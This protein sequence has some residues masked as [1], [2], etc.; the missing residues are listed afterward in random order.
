MTIFNFVSCLMLWSCVF[1][2]LFDV[3]VL[4][5]WL[6]ILWMVKVL[7]YAWWCAG[8]LFVY[9]DV[10]L[11]VM[12][13]LVMV[14]LLLR[15]VYYVGIDIVVIVTLMMVICTSCGKIVIKVPVYIKLLLLMI[16]S[17]LYIFI[18]SPI[19]I[20]IHIF[21]SLPIDLLI[22][23]LRLNYLLMW[24][25]RLYLTIVMQVTL[26]TIN[27]IND[28]VIILVLFILLCCCYNLT[29]Y[30]RLVVCLFL[31]WL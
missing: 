9:V 21:N 24:R 22:I 8:C 12:M 13:G 19:I 3:I 16:L 11:I 29:L 10:L 4:M 5:L 7:C 25:Y 6:E 28:I 30:C 20:P 1:V 31:V 17:L 2:I 23:I 15:L 26:T 14:L 18:F 27:L